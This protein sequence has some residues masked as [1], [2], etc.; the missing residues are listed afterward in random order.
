MP[1]SVLAF[2]LFLAGI[3][4]PSQTHTL[5]G[6]FI[7][8]PGWSEVNAN[9]SC[10]GTDDV[11]DIKPGAT[12]LLYTPAWTVDRK[13]SLGPGRLMRNGMCVFTFR[14]D[15]LPR[16]DRYYLEVATWLPVGF[17]YEELER[18]D[19]RIQISWGG[20]RPASDP[21]DIPEFLD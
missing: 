21:P 17:T 9:G 13:Q 3:A 8:E 2:L 1:A 19:W 5:G 10:Q 12:L 14:F 4:M 18:W 11:W 20:W 16:S 7:L 15:N 6:Y